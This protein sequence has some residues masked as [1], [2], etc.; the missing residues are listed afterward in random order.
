MLLWPRFVNVMLAV[1]ATLLTNALLLLLIRYRTSPLMHVYS[2]ILIAHSIMDLLYVFVCALT[3]VVSSNNRQAL[4]PSELI[5]CS[6]QFR[7]T[8]IFISC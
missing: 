1:V 7:S 3:A 4:S 2:R 6:K 8:E 5:N